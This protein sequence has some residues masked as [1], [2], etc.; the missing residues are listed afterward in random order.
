MLLRLVV[1]TEELQLCL[2]PL[3]AVARTSALAATASVPIIAYLVEV[4]I[5]CGAS[6]TRQSFE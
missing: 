5:K 4:C 1:Y 3:K 2:R 6:V